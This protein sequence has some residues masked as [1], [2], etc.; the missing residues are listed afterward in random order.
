MG[1]DG[2]NR[3]IRLGG[4]TEL[5]GHVPDFLQCRGNIFTSLALRSPVCSLVEEQ[6][7]RNEG[8]NSL[9]LVSE[10]PVSG[11]EILKEPWTGWDQSKEDGEVGDFAT[12]G[13]CQNGKQVPV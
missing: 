1:S 10:A 13:M 11:A 6:R 4:L 5:G 8:M 12:R 7:G 3:K 9:Q 2:R